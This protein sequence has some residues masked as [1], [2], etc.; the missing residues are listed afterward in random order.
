MQNEGFITDIS[1]VVLAGITVAYLKQADGFV[2]WI[3]KLSDIRESKEYKSATPDDRIESIKELGYRPQHLAL[4][5][6]TDDDIIRTSAYREAKNRLQKIKPKIAQLINSTKSEVTLISCIK[7]DNK[8]M[9]YEWAIT[10]ANNK[11]YILTC[12]TQP[13]SLPRYDDI[14]RTQTRLVERM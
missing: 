9:Y 3:K 13:D 10:Y 4:A 1:S 14:V 12:S 7:Q 6:N 11:K 2:K 5:S 8:N